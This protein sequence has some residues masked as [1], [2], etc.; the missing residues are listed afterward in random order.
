MRINRVLPLVQTAISRGLGAVSQVVLAWT[1]ARTLDKSGSGE[2]LYYLTCFVVLSQM[3]LMGTHQFAT[4][5]LSGFE[6][7]DK[8]ACKS[9]AQLVGV[10]LRAILLAAALI[11]PLGF[12]IDFGLAQRIGFGFFAGYGMILAGACVFAAGSLAIASHLHGARHFGASISFSHI[13]IPLVTLI[14]MLVTGSNTAHQVAYC[15]LAASVVILVFAVIYWKR[16]YQEA[17]IQFRGLYKARIPKASFDFWIVNA[18][19]LL[20]NWSPIFVAGL[21]LTTSELAELNIAQ[22]AGNLIN[23]VLIIVSFTFAPKFRLRFQSNDLSGLRSVIASC[24][25]LLIAMGTPVAIGVIVFA[26]QIMSLFGDKYSSGA[27]ALMIYAAGQYFNVITGSVNQILTMCN[28]EKALRNICMV[29]A[30]TSMLLGILL[31]YQFGAIGVAMAASTGLIVQN[32]LAVLKLR[33]AMGIWVFDVR[34]VKQIAET[35]AS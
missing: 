11:F 13:T 29:S 19:Q 25:R 16:V 20:M 1:V 6:T 8:D 2:F 4:R 18:S 34:G 31:T 24:S 30:T 22:R 35:H 9:A 26:P 14:L 12:L 32:V 17:E 10:H 33:I 3:M 27:V 23:F 5:E 28:F 7:T 21:L 15:H